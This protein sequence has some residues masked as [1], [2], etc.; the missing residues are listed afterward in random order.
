MSSN[1]Q[2]N[3]EKEVYFIVLTPSEEKVDFN[4]IFKSQDVPK[5][6][7]KKS[8]EKEK[9][10]FLEHNVFKLNIIKKEEK[11]EDEDKDEDE[12]ENGEEEHKIEYIVGN[13]AYDIIISFKD[14]SF[15]YDTQLQKGNK[16]LHNIVKDD[17]D[18]TI[19]PLYYKLDIFLEALNETNEKNKIDK[20]YDETIDL[21]KNKKKYSLLISLFLKIYDKNKDLCSKLLEIFEEINAK[22]NKDKDE[23][24]ISYLDKINKIY[25]NAESIITKNNYDEKNKK[26]FYGVLFSYLSNYDKDNFPKIIKDFSEGN[27]E[28][29]YEILII[30]YSHF[31][32]LNQN[33]EFYNNFLSYAIRKKKTYDIIER[34]LNY[35]KDIE[36][37]IYVINKNKVD[38]IK[39]DYFKNNPIS[40]SSDLKLIRRE[41]KKEINF[42]VTIIEDLIKFS[43]DNQ[44]LV[45]YLKRE[46]WINLLKQYN[47]ADMENIDNCYQL[48]ELYKKYYHLINKL[49]KET[50]DERKNEIKKDINKYYFRDEFA[51]ILNNNIKK[52]LEKEGNKE[53]DQDKLGIIE[54][55]NP[56]Y[57]SND[58]NDIERYK[59]NRET[60]IFNSIRFRNPTSGFKKSFIK[61]NFE[62]MFK[63]NIIEFLNKIISKIEDIPTFGTVMELIT[64]SRLEN[65]REY[66]YNLLKE[67]FEY[68]IKNQIKILE[69]KELDDAVKIISYFISRIFLEEGTNE[70]LEEKI[71]KLDDKIKSL[72]YNELMKTYNDKKYEK[73][74]QYIYYIFLNKLDDIDNIIKLIDSLGK[75]DKEEFLKELMKKCEFEKEEF[76]SNSENKK[77]KLLCYLNDNKKLNI[78]YNG[79]IESVLDDIRNDLG[80]EMDTGEITKKKLETFL[81]LKEEEKSDVKDEKD[82]NVK[83][84][85]KIEEKKETEENIII[86]KLSLITLVIDTYDPKKNYNDLK[87]I[88]LDINATIKDL[89]YIKDSIIIFHRKQYETEIR[90]LTEIIHEIETDPI[91]EFKNQIKKEKRNELLK[92]KQISI[93]INKIKDFL[94]FKKIFEKSTGKNQEQRYQDAKSKLDEIKNSFI[95]KSSSNEKS[96]DKKQQSNEEPLS[97]IEEIILVKYKDIFDEIKEE[98]SKKEDSVSNGF[99]EKMI[100]ICNITNN[101]TKEDLNI[102]IKSK[103]YEIVVKSIKFF[104]ENFGSKKLILPKNIELSKMNLKQLNTNL[105]VLKGSNIFDYST[106]SYFYKVFTSFYEK[107]EA[108]DFLISKID[109]NIANLKDKL[110]PTVKSISIKDIEDSIQCLN[111][112]TLLIKK[113]DALEIIN[114]I[115]YLDETHIDKFVSYSKHYPSIIELDRKNE[116]DIF[117][118]VYTMIEDAKLIFDLDNEYFCYN[119]GDKTFQKDINQLIDLKNKINIQHENS[120]NKEDEKKEEGK[121]KDLY[122]EKCDKLL[123]FKDIVSNFE[124][125]YDKI[126]ILRS[127]G[128]NIPIKIFISIKYSKIS[129]KF[130][131]DG[132]EK[133]FKDIKKYLFTIKN[134]YEEQLDTIYQNEKHLR[135]LYGKLFRKIK[136]HQ[137][138]NRPVSEILRYILNK[139]DYEDKIIDGEPFNVKQGD[140]FESEFKLYTKNIFKFMSKYIISLFE[141]NKLSYQKHYENMLIKGEKKYKGIYWYKCQDISMEEFILKLFRD[142]LDKLPIAQNILICSNETSI[143]EMQSFF[144]R[145]ILCD[146]NTLFIIEVLNSFSNFQ[147]NKMY[148]Y[149]DKLLS[150]KLENCENKKLNKYDTKDYL[151]SCIYFVY[152]NL[153][154]EYAFINELDK[155]IIQKQNKVSQDKNKV[156]ENEKKGNGDAMGDLNISIIS[157]NLYKIQTENIKVFSSDVC[158]LG[159]SFQ[160]KKLIKKNNDIYYHFPLGGRL[161]KKTIYEKIL[162]LLKKIKKD[163]KIRKDEENK[164][165]GKTEENKENQNDEENKKDEEYLEYNN[166]AVHLDL[167]ESEDTS[168]I[169]EFL[170]SFLITKF[171]NNNEDI[172]YIPNNIK[173]YVEIP[174][175]F[176]N[177]LV[178]YGILNVF[179]NEHIELGKLP[180]LELDDDTKNIFKRIIE[181]DENDDIEAF[182]RENI[183]LPNY[184]YHQ[185]VTFIKL[186]ISQFSLFNT[187]LKFTDSQ[188]NNITKECIDYFAKS[189]KYFTNGGFAKLIMNKNKEI[190]DKIDLCLEAYDNDLDKNSKEKN[191]K[192]EI[193]K[194]PLIFIDK[195]TKKFRFEMLPEIVEEDYQNIKNI[196]ILKKQVD[197]LYLIDA[198]GSMGDEINAANAH[199]I[200]IFE[201]MKTKYKEYKF[202]FGAVFYRD[203]IDSKDDKNEY[204][205]LT[206]NMDNLKKDIS[207]IKPYGG[208]DIPEDWVAGYKI[209]LNDIN[210]GKGTKLII[211]IA[212]AGAHGKE[213]SKNDK[214][215]QEGQKLTELIQECASKNINI[216]GFKIGEKP[217][218]SFEKISE[219]YNKYKLENKDSGQFIEIIN[220][221]RGED[222][223]KK[224]EVVSRNFLRFVFEAANQVVNPSYKYLK[225]LK[226][227][228]HLENDLIIN[229]PGK[230]SLISILDQDQ[231]NYVIT[232]DNYKKMV[233]LVY[234]IKANVPVIIMG[235]T[236]CGKTSLIVKLSEIINNGENKVEIINIHP[237]IT[238]DEICKRMKIINNKAKEQEF[239]DNEK[240]QKKE[241]WAFFDEINTCLSLSLL[242]EIFINRTFNG[243]K[244]E[245]NIK[246]IGACNPYR[247]RKITAE[248]CGLTR[249][250]DIENDLVYKVEQLPQSLL[251]YVFSFGSI[252]KEDEKKYIYSIIQKIFKEEEELHLLTTEAISQCH[253]FLRETF[254]DPSIVSLREIARFTSCVE[255]FHDYFIKK[256]QK[257]ES[258]LDDEIKK[259]FKIK[260]II[261]SIYLCYYIR[262]I[263]DVKRGNF[264][265]VLQK[266]LLK[267]VNVYS[268]QENDEE[269]ENTSLFNKIKNQNLRN[270]LYGKTF[271][272]F[273]DLLKIEEEFLLKQ[274]E[275]DKGIGQNDLLK[276][277]LFLL[278]LAV[279]TKIP[280][281]IVGKPGTGK[282]LSAQLI[283]NSMRGKYS[284]NEF[285]KKYPPIIQKYFQGSES[286]KADEVTELF[287][288]AENL[289]ENYKKIHNKSE[290]VPIFMI[291]F[292]ELGLAEKSPEN[293]LKV[294]HSKLEYDGKNEGVCF[295]G[296]SN[297]SLKFICAKFRRKARRIKKNF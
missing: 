267:I 110:D 114:Y 275:L 137:E 192:K 203:Q 46:F 235:E 211:H 184:S 87:K 16:Y 279:V 232:E 31:R 70:F 148:S 224:A 38:I 113:E 178:K 107:K 160:I 198:T 59:N 109:T 75:E 83:E 225:R 69:G 255:F 143:E 108:I 29:L 208:N 155:Y 231:I 219:V 252:R 1:Q 51:F 39:Y 259:C 30:Y 53:T 263:N 165:N 10:Y 118:E 64:V 90:Q 221:D 57:S 34:I 264:D 297:Y 4:K 234:R 293:P 294:L 284:K 161:T 191:E 169:N 269:N 223:K 272:Q 91:K 233:L 204:F 217:K 128:Y 21:Y 54:Q 76:Y 274:I 50:D 195:N 66:Y 226:Q 278:F 172:L 212:D 73:M 17:I 287:N 13:D 157:N 205:Q 111:H 230:K 167:I 166:I 281:I 36:T 115:K 291:L 48:R 81:N 98:L 44:I 139:V 256:R 45:I 222:E 215:P 237:G 283:Y 55:Y 130:I 23:E 210:W 60:S 26:N 292:D 28:I 206:D 142:K 228:L 199:V 104:F 216:I 158:G 119:I 186:F 246:L 280:V 265:N 67:K 238:E 241:L 105:K 262:L 120:K 273:S 41:D 80:K 145:A 52:F 261:C 127:K 168:L 276:E 93:D 207:K 163:T 97:T 19:I 58:K 35:I 85:K 11:E 170:F 78:N 282:S 129:Y 43:N 150:Y 239:I 153:D 56:Y 214:Y 79:K 189:T 289:Y 295:I 243:E 177:Y 194:T 257:N 240:N 40:L 42:I 154:N 296:I 164:K 220:C 176:E 247:R 71:G 125:I 209:A 22:G 77:I 99:I 122:Y 82:I 134:D 193:L 180:K 12:D 188:D 249:E 121:K 124:A 102:L 183:G 266:T 260:S 187:K 147:H 15:I 47:K 146:Y 236:G 258:G 253:I 3:S 138:G 156:E 245:D 65:K 131:E 6:I 244:L 74:K 159:K 171:Y 152:K 24:L 285:F 32:D 277:N 126:K 14:N 7:Y 61:L 175:S 84:D 72:I 133:E 135:F 190:K 68:I 116:K 132:E 144:Y 117:E 179:P 229:E 9:G 92:L 63:E 200:H 86:Q 89:N 162:K 290:I 20:L 181:K 27:E 271:S 196:K 218:Q 49:Y 18:Q 254:D 62:T 37:F 95:T 182:I 149:I 250:D 2:N 5:S 8:I 103:K 141:K 185:V 151:N 25:S 202:R 286:T 270:E 106:D 174:N 123:F 268:K 201:K 140:D 242:T 94:L 173:I 197:I 288:N 101:E 88:I 112:F 96:T 136:L 248:K 213:Y 251:Y 227:I 100:S 33:S